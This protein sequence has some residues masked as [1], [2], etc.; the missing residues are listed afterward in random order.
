MQSV[1]KKQPAVPNP[2][3][4]P[5]R[6]N[7]KCSYDHCRPTHEIPEEMK[8]LIEENIKEILKQPKL[9]SL[10]NRWYVVSVIDPLRFYYPDMSEVSGQKVTKLYIQQVGAN[11]IFEYLY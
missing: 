5:C 1:S 8:E 3:T 4:I 10:D 9:V 6:R 11:T 7:I 2:S